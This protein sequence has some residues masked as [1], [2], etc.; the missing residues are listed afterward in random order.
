MQKDKITMSDLR[1]RL[2]NA[3]DD[4]MTGDLEPA[5]AAAVAKLAAQLNQSL[6]TELEA[7]KLHLLKKIQEP[8]EIGDM[9]ISDSIP[10]IEHIPDETNQ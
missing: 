10:Q 4:V 3:I 9:P 5:R 2:Y 8:F 7:Q 6:A 1:G